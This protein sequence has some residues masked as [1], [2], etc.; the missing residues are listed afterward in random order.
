MESEKNRWKEE[1]EDKDMRFDGKRRGEMEEERWDEKKK[2]EKGEGRTEKIWDWRKRDG[3]KW[4]KVD[5]GEVRLDWKR[6]DRTRR[7]YLPTPP[8]GQDMTQGQFLSG[9]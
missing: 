9:V 2:M 5:K 7:Y 8:L 4:G 6:S 1:T 3:K